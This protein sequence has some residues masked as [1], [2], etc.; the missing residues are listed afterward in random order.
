VDLFR[1]EGGPFIGG[2]GRGA[3]RPAWS[4][5]GGHR[6][7]PV[8]TVAKARCGLVLRHCGDVGSSVAQQGDEGSRGE[9]W[10]EVGVRVVSLLFFQV[11]WPGFGQGRQGTDRG[12]AGALLGGQGLGLGLPTTVANS[13]FDFV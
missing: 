8:A 11:S 3:G 1:K 5:H 6:R 7:V 12:E 9:Q 2:R 13:C 4:G 10:P